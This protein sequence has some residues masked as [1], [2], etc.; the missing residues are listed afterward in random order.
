MTIVVL[1]GHTLNPGD[2][3]WDRVARLGELTIHAR[4]PA[5]EIVARSS[6]AEILLT[7]KTPLTAEILAQLP[8]LKC[9]CVLATGVNVVDVAAARARGVVV[10]NVPEYSTQSVAQLVFALLLEMCHHVG[11]HDRLIHAGEWSRREWCFWETPQ[12][13][14]AGKTLGI[15]GY[16]RIGRRVAA[17]G[18]ALGMSILAFS[19]TR[20]EPASAELGWGTIDEVFA[21]SD[22]VSLHIPLT[23]EVRGMVNARLLGSMKKDAF[24]INTARG[25]LINDADLAAALR[26]GKIAGAG[27]DV[28]TVEPINADNPLLAAP[29]C[30]ITPH[31]AWATLA[32]RKR[33]MGTTEE[34]IAAFLAGKPQNV[35]N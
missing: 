31:Y 33:L 6:N 34:N 28:T 13:E 25:A 3:S 11:Q 29:N 26:E 27:L 19:R 30:V 4:T 21:A 35:V 1:D 8:R 15:V 17:I 14:L 9:I 7:N 10:C 5:D 24:L 20:R 23:P 12:V 18:R 22:V 2:L 32:A 16:G